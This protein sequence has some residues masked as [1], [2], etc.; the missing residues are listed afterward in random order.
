VSESVAINRENL[1][2]TS[3]DVYSGALTCGVGLRCAFV[4]AGADSACHDWGF[5]AVT[6]RAYRLRVSEIGNW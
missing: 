1:M 2:F 4:R 5:S 3:A 6:V